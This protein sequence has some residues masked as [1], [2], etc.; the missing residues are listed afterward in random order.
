MPHLFRAKREQVHFNGNQSNLESPKDV[1]LGI[2]GEPTL[3]EAGRN[4]FTKRGDDGRRLQAQST[5]N[6]N[7]DR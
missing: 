5:H 3:I 2:A 1:S 6:S 7:L 4:K